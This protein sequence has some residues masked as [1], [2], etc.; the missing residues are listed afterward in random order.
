MCRH[1]R[2]ILGPSN[3]N[4][5]RP[6]QYRIAIKVIIQFLVFVLV[7]TIFST[8]QA[9]G[10]KDCYA[11]KVLVKHFCVLTITIHGD[12]FPPAITCCQLDEAEISA[13]KLV[14]LAHDCNKPLPVGNKC[15][16]K[17]GLLG[18]RRRRHIHESS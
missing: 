9:W 6:Y 2:A 3:N 4:T 13:I 7:S 12:Y 11:Q 16:S 18:H 15:G 5:I 8:H 17:V 14:R 10:E 1:H